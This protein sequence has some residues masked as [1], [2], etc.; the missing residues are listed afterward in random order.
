MGTSEGNLRFLQW[1]ASDFPDYSN[2]DGAV[3]L[4]IRVCASSSAIDVLERECHRLKNVD[5]WKLYRSDGIKACRMLP[6]A[7]VVNT[8]RLQTLW[9]PKSEVQCTEACAKQSLPGLCSWTPEDLSNTSQALHGCQF[10][11]SDF[12]YGD[13]DGRSSLRVCKPSSLD[14]CETLSDCC[15]GDYCTHAW[16]VHQI[17]DEVTAVSICVD[18]VYDGEH[19]SKRD[20]CL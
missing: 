8:A 7:A 19:P 10:S 12:V 17:S 9:G 14:R 1:T 6:D 15:A 16:P 4:E 13:G 2:V 11:P 18:K 3:Y 5:C 20:G